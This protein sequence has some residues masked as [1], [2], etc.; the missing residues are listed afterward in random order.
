MKKFIIA[1]C[2]ILA[3]NGLIAM[4]RAAD[5]QEPK[6]VPKKA[7]N[8][9]SSSPLCTAIQDGNMQAIDEL[10]AAKVDINSPD[11]NG[12]LPLWYAIEIGSLPI[13][14]K[15][16]TNADRSQIKKAAETRSASRLSFWQA[17]VDMLTL[18]V[19]F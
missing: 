17:L 9:K 11:N 2:C 8:K 12:I 16:T 3:S 6:T 7:K 18:F 19:F 14:Q 10:L 5:E 15:L 4:K 13:V 1:L